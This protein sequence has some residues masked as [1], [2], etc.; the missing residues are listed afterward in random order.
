[1]PGD[2]LV[3]YIYI[4]VIAIVVILI[5]WYLSTEGFK[6]VDRMHHP[7][8][9]GRQVHHMV[10]NDAPNFGGIQQAYNPWMNTGRY[11]M[12]RRGSHVLQNTHKLG[13]LMRDG[14]VPS[15]DIY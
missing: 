5:I 6:P 13:E 7:L 11:Q 12:S 10:E 2:N 8:Y 15:P 14:D 3:F 4:V 9:H 1:M